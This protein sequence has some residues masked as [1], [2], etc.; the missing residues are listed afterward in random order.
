MSNIHVLEEADD[1]RWIA[2]L[3]V[4]GVSMPDGDYYVPQV[5]L[6]TGTTLNMDAGTWSMIENAHYRL[7]NWDHVLRWARIF[8]GVNARIFTDT[9]YSQGDY[10][11]ILAW[12][13]AEWAEM[14]GL[15]ADYI[16]SEEDV[17]DFINWARGDVYYVERQY[18]V[19]YTNDADPS[20]TITNWER[21]TDEPV[22]I[23][24]TDA[25]ENITDYNL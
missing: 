21:D 7:D 20:D 6:E 23:Y 22:G 24:F 15:D 2:E 1:T 5:R 4:D 3:S 11:T 9:G 16:P 17:S 18:K 12:P 14:V 19:T 10:Y 13:S 8:H 25:P